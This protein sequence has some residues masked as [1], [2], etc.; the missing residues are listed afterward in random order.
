MDTYLA[1][2][3]L[4]VTMEVSRGGIEECPAWLFMVIRNVAYPFSDTP[5][6]EGNTVRRDT[7]TKI[8]WSPMT[9]ESQK[10]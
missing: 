9:S 2:A 8:L 10:Q 3:L 7:F 5:I 6:L 1:K 4:K